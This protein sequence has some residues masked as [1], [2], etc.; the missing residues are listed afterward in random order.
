MKIILH[1]TVEQ[2]LLDIIDTMHT[3]NQESTTRAQGIIGYVIHNDAH[4]KS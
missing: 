3:K 2:W 4:S 1:V